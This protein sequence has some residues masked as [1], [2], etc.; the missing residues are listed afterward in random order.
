MARWASV[1][2]VAGAAFT[3]CA[4]SAATPWEEFLQTPSPERAARVQIRSYTKA[5]VG[6]EQAAWDLRLLEVQVLSREPEAVRLAFRVRA[7]SDG[8]VAEMLDI[9]L[10][11]LIRIDAALFLREA[12][13]ADAASKR[14]D[15]L[16]GNFGPEYVDRTEAHGYEAAQRIEALRRVSDP[17]L[18]KMRD[19]CVAFL[20]K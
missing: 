16:L 11:R 4:S 14:L 15:S 20:Q 5:T 3:L 7:A 6:P 17:A 12:L 2:V 13:R 18:K 9:M 19:Q 8:S 10:G 1:A